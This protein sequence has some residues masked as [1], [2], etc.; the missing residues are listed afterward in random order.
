[1]HLSGMPREVIVASVRYYLEGSALKPE[2]HSCGIRNTYVH[3]TKSAKSS[4]SGV[5]QG[6]KGKHRAQGIIHIWLS[7]KQGGQ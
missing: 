1:M 3:A 7:H 6:D 4:I 2:E 5:E